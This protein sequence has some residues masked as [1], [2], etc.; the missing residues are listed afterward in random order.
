MILTNE[1]YFS[2]AANTEYMSASQYKA[3][4]KCEAA[5]I[6]EIR[7]EYKR[8]VTTALLVGSYVDANFEGTLD[9]FKSQHPEIFKRDGTLKAEYNQANT[10]I[11]RCEE[12]EL[13][14][15]LMSGKKQVIKTGTISGV[16]FKI[17]MDSLLDAKQTAAIA[18]KFPETAEM[19]GMLDGLIVDGKVMRDMNPVWQDGEFKPFVEAW[20]YDIQGA[21]YQEIEGK[22]LPFV[23]AVATKE[24]V[25]DINA[26]F[27][28]DTA[29]QAAMDEVE[30]NAPV[31]QEIKLGKIEPKRCEHCEYCRATRKLTTF[32]NYWEVGEC[33]E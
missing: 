9:L 32:V 13:F 29:L 14:M 12:D 33:A 8:P 10:I 1:N 22:M 19:L 15:M 21:V 3:F 27:I 25:P 23:L 5:A 4:S 11:A 2:P 6:A 20:G 16:P 17:K 18:E 7:G 31:Y 24:N 30:A 26:L 28:P